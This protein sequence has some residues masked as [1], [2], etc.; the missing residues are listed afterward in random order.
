MANFQKHVIGLVFYPGMT[1]LDMVG[2]HQV[3]S[4]LPGVKLHRI[5][6]TLDPI[7]TDDGLMILPDTTFENCSPWM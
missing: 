5:W 2:P 4:A 7:A 3:F 6:K 1:S